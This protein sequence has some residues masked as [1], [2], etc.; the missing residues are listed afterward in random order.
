MLIAYIEC[1]VSNV[2]FVLYI[3]TLKIIHGSHNLL[4]VLTWVGRIFSILS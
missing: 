2:C 3:G 1:R 4:G